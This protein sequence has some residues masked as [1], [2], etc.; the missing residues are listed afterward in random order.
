[1]PVF[2]A[3]DVSF[4]H[5][6]K[7]ND[8][9]IPD[10][11]GGPIPSL[12]CCAVDA[13]FFAIQQLCRNS[14][15]LRI[16]NDMKYLLVYDVGVFY[17]CFCHYGEPLSFWNCVIFNIWKRKL[18]HG[19]ENDQNWGDPV[20]ARCDAHCFDCGLQDK[21]SN[22]FGVFGCHTFE[23]AAQKTVVALVYFHGV[24]TFESHWMSNN[25]AFSGY[26][27]KPLAHEVRP[28]VVAY[29]IWRILQ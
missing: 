23:Y 12:G 14:W 6:D 20:D 22:E 26:L 29:D 17:S 21:L 28:C 7:E 8:A 24:S 11:T 27:L 1:M 13:E 18:W 5:K 10:K 15:L 19:A 9:I 16:F 3:V 4:V 25:S 2:Q